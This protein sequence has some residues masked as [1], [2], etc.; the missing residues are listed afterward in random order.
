LVKGW[1]FPALNFNVTDQSHPMYIKILLT[2]TLLA[3]VKCSFSQDTTGGTK[4]NF[5][6]PLHRSKPRPV[7]VKANTQYPAANAVGPAKKKN[8]KKKI[9]KVSG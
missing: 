6:F 4:P 5:I 2:L 9:K 3:A 7:T 1:K 8:S